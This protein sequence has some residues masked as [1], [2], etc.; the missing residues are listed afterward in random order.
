LPVAW[1]SFSPE[2]QGNCVW[3]VE[4]AS[5]ATP[6]RSMA[7]ASPAQSA[8]HRWATSRPRPCTPRSEPPKAAPAFVQSRQRR[9]HPSSSRSPPSCPSHDQSD[10][11]SAQTP[12]LPPRRQRA[13]RRYSIR[14]TCCSLSRAVERPWP[15][16]AP[17]HHPCRIPRTAAAPPIIPLPSPRTDPCHAT[18]PW[19]PSPLRAT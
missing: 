15:T 16:P 19:L 9:T 17:A 1:F 10:R 13:A 5:W 7:P 3:F 11:R 14:T 18:D 4:P 6:A 8:P 12:A 2:F